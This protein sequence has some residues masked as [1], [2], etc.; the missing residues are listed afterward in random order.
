MNRTAALRVIVLILAPC[1]I[2][3][4]GDGVPDLVG[5]S[6]IPPIVESPRADSGPLGEGTAPLPRF[7]AA[8]DAPALLPPVEMRSA[9]PRVPAT[10]P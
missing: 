4:A 2:G 9:P 1:A 8:G 6:G 7:E 5:P 3:L 10:R